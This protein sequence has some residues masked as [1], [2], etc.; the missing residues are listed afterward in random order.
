MEWFPLN[1]APRAGIVRRTRSRVSSGTCPI[2]Q[3]DGSWAH[4]KRAGLLVLTPASFADRPSLIFGS[5]ITLTD[6]PLGPMVVP[7]RCDG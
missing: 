4:S 1:V 7:R 5:S 6:T 2:G 3:P